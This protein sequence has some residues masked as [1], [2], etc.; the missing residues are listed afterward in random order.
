L[1]RSNDYN[2]TSTKLSKLSLES[3]PQQ[4]VSDKSPPPAYTEEEP[5]DF[6]PL[7]ALVDFKDAGQSHTSTVTN[8]Q[9]IAHLKLLSVFADLRAAISTDNGLFGIHDS[10]ADRFLDEQSK[11]QALARIREKRWAVYTTR[12]VDRY[13]NWWHNCALSSGTALSVDILLQSN[14]AAIT[15]PRTPVVWS[16]KDLPPLG[17][18]IIKPVQQWH[19]D[20]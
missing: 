20:T 12:A 3:A 16:S 7:P 6:P 11:N 2:M 18:L 17:E 13:T 10:I 5:A 1:N 15:K 8:T 19:T 4:P 9:C 14:Y